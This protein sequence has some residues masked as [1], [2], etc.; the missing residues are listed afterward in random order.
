MLSPGTGAQQNNLS[1][2]IPFESYLESLR[3][4]AGI[5]GMSA[6]MLQDGEVVW[7]RGLGFQN[8]ESRIRATPDT[9]YPIADLNQTLTA[10]LVLHCTEQRRLDLGDPIRRYGESVAG[11]GRDHSAAA[12]PHVGRRPARLQYDPDATRS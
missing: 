2:L 3:V 7:E 1:G 6:I 10:T 11:T 4:Q 8:Q 12:Q 9:P 5:P